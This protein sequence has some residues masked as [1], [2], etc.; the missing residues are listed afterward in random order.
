MNSC[1]YFDLIERYLAERNLRY[2]EPN[3]ELVKARKKEKKFTLQEHI[4]A[5][6]LSFLSNQRKWK[7]IE[8]NITKIDKIFFDYIPEK[9][10]EHT[11]EYFEKSLKNI[12]CGNRRIKKQMQAMFCNIELFKKITHEFDSVDDF[13]TS[14]PTIYEV[15][16]KFTKSTSNYK[17]KEMGIGLC[18]EYLRNVGVDLVKPDTH[19]R[20]FLG[21][22]RM[23]KSKKRIA[24]AKEV[25][26]QVELLMQETGRSAVEIDNLIWSYCADGYGAICVANPN[27]EKCCINKYCNKYN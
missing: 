10:E 15:L 19:L 17:L 24:T 4:R 2:A 11:A 26:E 5:M 12:K 18:S 13:I 3:I 20:R 8:Q 16:M 23:G 14:Q 1:L 7:D 6:I 27:C 22:A 25:F 21:N 9:I